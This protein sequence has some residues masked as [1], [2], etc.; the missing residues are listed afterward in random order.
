MFVSDSLS[1]RVGHDRFRH[2]ILDRVPRIDDRNLGPRKRRRILFRFR[3]FGF[4]Q[5]WVYID[6][7]KIGNTFYRIIPSPE[8]SLI[9]NCDILFVVQNLKDILGGK[10]SQKMLDRIIDEADIIG[11]HKVWKDEFMALAKESFA[12]AS[13]EEDDQRE[14][15][16]TDTIRTGSEGRRGHAASCFAEFDY[17]NAESLNCIQAAIDAEQLPQSNLDL[18]PWDING[19]DLGVSQFVIEKEKSVRKVRQLA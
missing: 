8:Y 7:G 11:D 19:D 5:Q 17:V 1:A 16:V 4:R 12:D 2:D 3:S 15:D 10:L 6:W 9:S 14:K 13:D 18:L